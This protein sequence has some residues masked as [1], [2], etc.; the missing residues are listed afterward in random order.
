MKK[1]K[2]TQRFYS[3]SFW[4]KKHIT[5]FTKEKDRKFHRKKE[6]AYIQKNTP[7][8]QTFGIIFIIFFLK[9][10]WSMNTHGTTIKKER[11]TS[12]SGSLC[13]KKKI[14]QSMSLVVCVCQSVSPFFLL[15]IIKNHRVFV[16][17][18]TIYKYTFKL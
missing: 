6:N 17:A 16:F 12:R 3:F 8:N 1:A 13:T 11:I 5:F 14:N 18:I 2:R 15:I 9:K 10:I 4:K 7:K